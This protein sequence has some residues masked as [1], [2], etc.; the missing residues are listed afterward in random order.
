VVTASSCRVPLFESQKVV[1]T[2][3][4]IRRDGEMKATIDRIENKLS[5]LLIR[6]KEN[7]KFNISLALL[8]EGSK[9]GD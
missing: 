7:I 5:I 3:L 6:N 1:D 4:V 9:E 2:F 8:H